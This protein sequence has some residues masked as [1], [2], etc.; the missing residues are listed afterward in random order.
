MIGAHKGDDRRNLGLTETYGQAHRTRAFMKV[1]V[2]AGD[3]V[4]SRGA[5]YPRQNQGSI[6]APPV[7]SRIRRIGPTESIV[8]FIQNK[9]KF[10]A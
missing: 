4:L 9:T 3:P 6:T 8:V 5:V 7:R 1:E 10:L 2:K